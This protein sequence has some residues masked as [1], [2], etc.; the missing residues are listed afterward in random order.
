K[1]T[2][3]SKGT[4]EN[5]EDSGTNAT[6]ERPETTS[7]T[8]DV[9]LPLQPLHLQLGSQ[10]H[11]KLQQWRDPTGEAESSKATTAASSTETPSEGLST[12]EHSRNVSSGTGDLEG[13]EATTTSTGSSETPSEGISSTTEFPKTVS[14]ENGDKGVLKATTTADPSVA[15][16][17][18]ITSTT[19]LPGSLSSGAG[20]LEGPEI[21]TT[22][23]V[24]ECATG[25]HKC[26]ETA[27]CHNY[28]GG[29]ACFCP[30]GYRKM[31]KGV[32]VDIDECA[33]SHGGC[34]SGNATC[35]NKEGS[36][37]C[38]CNDGFVGDG[39][40]CMPLEKRGCTEAEWAEAN[41]GRNHMCTVDGSGKK[42]CDMCK[43]GFEMK[44]GE[45]VDINECAKPGLNMCDKNAVC[46]NLMGTYACQ[47][48][49]GFRGDG[50]MCDDEDE[51]RMMPCHPQAECHNK[52]GS[53]E[54]KCPDGFEDIDECAENR[55]NCDPASSTC[56]NTDGGFTCE[57]YE[58]YE[59]TGG[60]CV[61]IDECE[62]GVAGCHS[63]A[64]CINQPGSC[65]CKC[66]HGFTGDGT[67]CNAMK[68]ESN[69]TCTPEWQRLCRKESRTCHLDE[70][71]VPQCGSCIEGHQ[72]ING[73]CLPE[74]SGGN[75]AD[76][77]KNNCDKNAECIDVRP[78]RHFCTC[79]VGYIGDGMRCDDIDE[80]TLDGICDPHATCHNL[81]GSFE[82]TCNSGYVGSGIICD[83]INTTNG[84]NTTDRPNCHLD[85]RLCHTNA[86]CMEDGICKCR[87]GYEG[88]GI[89]NCTEVV[90]TNITFTTTT[91]T[92]VTSSA[93]TTPTGVIK[94]IDENEVVELIPELQRR[95]QHFFHALTHHRSRSKSHSDQHF[96]SSKHHYSYYNSHS[97]IKH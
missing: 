64:M 18:G 73:T 57:C 25:L 21:T 39:Y 93:P 27:R 60:V 97:R 38:K 33:E 82:C 7:T 47:C 20:D 75:C 36:Y 87:R 67:Q 35:V 49:K 40:K 84:T 77:T 19:E 29:Y 44:N 91:S 89:Q 66:V 78:G 85:S 6:S 3:D 46:N 79:K 74:Q 92:V 62:R 22:S 24:D 54:C 30:M 13:L 17:E 52:P 2:K 10:E 15:P 12:T 65:G 88:D 69:T 59:G 42:D 94:E 51:C 56:V 48:K 23:D 9:H 4:A 5:P 32:C 1:P 37:G 63:M 26:D 90:S 31:D 68:R 70:E 61:D 8:T 76:P 50:Y 81:P 96:D 86:E 71:D 41:C 11:P 28:V 83:S 34:C 95:A 53:F 45:C 58:G 43:M 72:L 16:K 80:C 14:S 55:H